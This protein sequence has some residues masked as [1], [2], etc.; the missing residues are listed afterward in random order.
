MRTVLVLCLL[1]ALTAAKFCPKEVKR[2][3]CRAKQNQYKCAVFFKQLFGPGPKKRKL[4]WIGALPDILNNKNKKEVQDILGDNITP[5]SFNNFEQCDDVGANAKCYT[6]L[7]QQSLE[8][9]DSCDRSL[10]NSGGSDTIGNFL[11]GQVRRWLKR[12]AS[13]KENGIPAPGLELPF[14]YS[15]C[16]GNWTPVNNGTAD[17]IAQE[18]LCCTNQGKYYKCDETDFARGC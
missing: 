1:L 13:F 11:C 4:T 3:K 16:G 15:Q 6:L 10:I 8:P 9:L 17:L 18:R 14:Y 12:S 2:D 7:N 5:E